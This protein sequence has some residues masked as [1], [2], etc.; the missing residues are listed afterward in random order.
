MGLNLAQEVEGQEDL[1]DQGGLEEG[2]EDPAYHQGSVEGAPQVQRAQESDLLLALQDL[3]SALDPY[4]GENRRGD[5]HLE[6]Q[7]SLPR[8]FAPTECSYV[9]E[10]RTD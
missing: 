5:P 4:L 7:P 3:E 10:A 1:E 8:T 2:G 9:T 6:G